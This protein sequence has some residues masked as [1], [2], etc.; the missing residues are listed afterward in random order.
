MRSQLPATLSSGQARASIRHPLTWWI[1][2]IGLA[3][4]IVRTDNS[5]VGLGVVGVVALVVKTQ[6]QDAPWSKSFWWSL[7]F[8]LWIIAVRTVIAVLIGIPIP[9]T[10]LF[11]LP[12]IP[13]PS[14]IA[15][16]RIGGTVTLER[17]GSSIHEGVIIASVIALLG[18]ATSLTSPHRLLR[19]TPV[20]IYEIGVSLVIAT[21]VLPQLVASISRIRRAQ[22]LRGN[23]KPKW[24]KIALPLLEDALARSLELAAAM[25]SRGYGA[26]RKRSRYRPTQWQ[27]TDLYIIATSIVALLFLPWI[28]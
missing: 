16:I 18:A 25:D 13:L 8:G 27:R 2:S 24:R 26:S 11:T 28:A 20:F 17:L 6:S 4:A 22:I 7:K 5:F 9:G 19:I 15:G 1:W 12:I 3:L 10:T 14:W 21:S 23:D